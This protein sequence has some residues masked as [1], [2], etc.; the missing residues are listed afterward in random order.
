M[1]MKSYQR[2]PTKNPSKFRELVGPNKLH[3]KI[4]PA[5]R[6]YTHNQSNFNHHHIDE[7]IESI[8][9]HSIQIKLPPLTLSSQDVLGVNIFSQTLLSP[10]SL[11]PLLPPK[12]FFIYD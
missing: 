1:R 2:S 4:D 7:P 5:N 10:A 8:V 3:L 12:F 9:G 6:K 11:C